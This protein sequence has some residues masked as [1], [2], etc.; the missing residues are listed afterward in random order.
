VWPKM[1]THRMFLPHAATALEN[2]QPNL[3]DVFGFLSLSIQ[4]VLR[5]RG[6]QNRNNVSHT[7]ANV[8][9]IRP[10]WSCSQALS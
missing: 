4:N 1:F 5:S 10:V 8:C 6:I 3:A 9:R 7:S 2:A